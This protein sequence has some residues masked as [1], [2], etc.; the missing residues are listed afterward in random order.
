MTELRETVTQLSQ[1]GDGTAVRSLLEAAMVDASL[2]AHR[3]ECLSLLIDSLLGDDLAAEAEATYLAAVADPVVARG[4]YGRVG[5]YYYRVEALPELAAWLTTLLDAPTLSTELKVESWRRYT[6]VCQQT[7]LLPSI[8]DRVPYLVAFD[9]GRRP[10][11]M[12]AGARALLRS[13][14]AAL[15]AQYLDAVMAGADDDRAVVVVVETARL[16]GMLKQAQLDEAVAFIGRTECALPDRDLASRAKRLTIAMLAANRAV[17]AEALL[18]RLIEAAPTAPVSGRMAAGQWLE[19]ARNAGKPDL[20]LERLG[21]L[22]DQA[23][24]LPLVFREFRTDFYGIMDGP[25]KAQREAGQAL[26]RRITMHADVAQLDPTT[27]AMMSLDAAFYR[28]EFAAALVLL[29]VG[30]PDQTEEWQAQL[31]NKVAGHLALSEGRTDDAIACFREHMAVVAQWEGPVRNSA[32]NLDM[33]KE[34]VLGFNEK[35]IG[36]ILKAAG[37]RETEATAA[38]AKAREYYLAGLALLEEDSAEYKSAQAELALVPNP[39][40]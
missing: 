15:L 32:E 1:S 10:S 26:L 7:E 3:G 21:S 5:G 11:L 36:D 13:G 38:Y 6:S 24:P 39:Q 4:A 8:I 18:V 9:V 16:D 27:L 40:G 12:G 2:Q 35:R 20:V 17:E 37:G 23:L 30:V 33:H 25:D 28:N 34:V 29:K 14:D 22:L 19:L 31:I